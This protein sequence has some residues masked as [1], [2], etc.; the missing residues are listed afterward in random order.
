GPDTPP[1]PP[2][3]SKKPAIVLGAVA[4]VA[5]GVGGALLGVGA[6]KK[7]DA[8]TL[9]DQIVSNKNACV[10]GFT[11]LDSRC[12]DLK[13]QFDSA[14][15]LQNIGGVTMAVG[16]AAAI[17]AVTYLLLPPPK[18]KDSAPLKVAPLAGPEQTGFV[19]SGSF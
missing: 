16:G 19:V 10:P 1:P 11:N 4:V 17:A 12:A 8:N 6:G 2:P 9:R 7:G 13:S 5:L 18:N 15:M 14:H 3:R